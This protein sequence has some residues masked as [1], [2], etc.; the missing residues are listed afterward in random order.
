[1]VDRDDTVSVVPNEEVA[2]SICYRFGRGMI[3][4]IIA[5]DGQT[6]KGV[7]TERV[8]AVRKTKKR[9]A[10]VASFRRESLRKRFVRASSA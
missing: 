3:D 1:M 2:K 9:D 4:S 5:A 8:A 10:V 7:S 6:R